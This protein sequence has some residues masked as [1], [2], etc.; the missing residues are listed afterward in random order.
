[1]RPN[2]GV[3][4]E[5]TWSTRSGRPVWRREFTPLSEMARLIDLVKFKGVV[6]GSRRSGG[7]S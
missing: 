7:R 5:S 3:V 4:V 1:M 2:I 6:E